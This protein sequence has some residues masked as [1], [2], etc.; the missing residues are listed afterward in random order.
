MCHIILMVHR[1][2]DCVFFLHI[3]FE[4]TNDQN[5]LTKIS[6]FFLTQN[7]LYSSKTIFN[8]L[9]PEFFFQSVFERYPKIGSNCLPTHRH[10]TQRTFS[11]FSSN[12][13]IGIFEIRTLL[14]ALGFKGL[15]IVH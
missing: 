13:R 7:S 12:F 6:N 5:Q 3:C 15:N 1:N 10:R 11:Y 2:F 14:C 8:P 4:A 9:V